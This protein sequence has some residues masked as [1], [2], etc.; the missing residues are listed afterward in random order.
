MIKFP[1]T[2]SIDLRP[3]CPQIYDQFTINSCVANAACFLYKY[4]SKTSVEPSRLNLYNNIRKRGRDSGGYILNA[5]KTLKK[6]GIVSEK[7]EPYKKKLK[8]VLNIKSKK[9]KIKD[10]CVIPQLKIELIECL[11]KNNPFIFSLL[12]DSNFKEIVQKSA[13]YNKRLGKSTTPHALVCVGYDKLTDMFLIA[14]SWGDTFGKKGY[15][16]IS[17]NIILDSRYCYDFYYF[18]SGIN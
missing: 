18:N 8:I 1:K 9:Y 15:F 14:N 13:V 17:S 7:L 6:N 3:N 2:F 12:L 16:V 5:L 10:Y 11:K 4:Y